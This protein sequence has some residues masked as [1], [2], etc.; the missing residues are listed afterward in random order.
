MKKLL[1]VLGCG[2]S[3]TSVLTRMLVASGYDQPYVTASH[4]EDTRVCKI[5]DDLLKANG[6]K[7]YDVDKVIKKIPSKISDRIKELTD[8]Y[9]QFPNPVLKC[10]RMVFC[11]PAWLPHIEDPSYIGIYRREDEV[12]DSQN[13]MHP[14]VSME[15]SLDY[16]FNHN[17]QL[18]RWVHEL[19]FPVLSLNGPRF[20]EEA[21]SVFKSHLGVKRFDGRAFK[22]KSVSGSCR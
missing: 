3:G 5:N 22:S 2:R 16:W 4:A 1:L 6:F 11:L 13:R 8:E 20:L 17:R 15:E 7:Y 12:A 18:M 19:D 9:D 21:E 10:P 14:E